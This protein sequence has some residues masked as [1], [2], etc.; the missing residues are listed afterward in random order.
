[1]PYRRL[2][3]TDQARLRALRIAIDEHQKLNDTNNFVLSYRLIQEAKVYLNQF[4]KTL[5]QYRQAL[6]AQIEANRNSQNV[7][8]NAR[9]YVSHFIQVMNLCVI[10]NEIKREHKE[11]YKLA[12]DDFAVPDLST[13]AALLEW[14]KN[15]IEGEETRLR[16]G[17]T[18]IY[19][20]SIAK[21]KVH[22]D[23]FKEHKTEQAVYQRNTSRFLEAVA[24]MRQRGDEIIQQMWNEVEAH[25]ASLPPYDRLQA[26]QKYGLVYYYRRGEAE[27]RPE[28]EMAA[29]TV[30]QPEN[31]AVQWEELTLF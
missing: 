9:L 14:G 24:E 30:K 13:E 16:S 2:P 1:M 28:S 11:L 26:C 19:N 25:Y 3:N 21:V 12:P 6:E 20:P 29:Q 15:L 17:G 27:L 8:K 4:D 18:Q 10:R 5:S 23:K 31:T 22:Y 7:I